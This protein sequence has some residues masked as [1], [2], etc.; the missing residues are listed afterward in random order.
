MRMQLLSS[1]QASPK[2]KYYIN[3]FIFKTVR[4]EYIDPELVYPVKEGGYYNTC[5]LCY[6]FLFLNFIGTVVSY[7][8]GT[9]DKPDKLIKKTV[10]KE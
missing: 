8:Y 9:G 1:L 5:R 6:V 7:V 3:I 4:A 10:P 2:I